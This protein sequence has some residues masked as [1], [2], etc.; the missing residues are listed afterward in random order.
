MI[1]KPYPVGRKVEGEQITKYKQ[2]NEA[3]RSIRAGTGRSRE[4]LS[5]RERDRGEG[6][7]PAHL[8]L[9]LTETPLVDKKEHPLP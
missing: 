6:T 3:H 2:Y 4:R 1:E 7:R 5:E 9:V 8:Q